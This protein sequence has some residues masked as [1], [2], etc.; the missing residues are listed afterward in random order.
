MT[1]D[2]VCDGGLRRT[3]LH[4]E[5]EVALAAKL[6]VTEGVKRMGFELMGYPFLH[7]RWE[8]LFL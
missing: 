3:I 2:A 6:P 7:F 5:V 8:L 1:Q 4:K